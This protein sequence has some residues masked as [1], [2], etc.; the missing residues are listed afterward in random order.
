MSQEPLPHHHHHHH[1]HHSHHNKSTVQEFIHKAQSASGAAAYA[2]AVRRYNFETQ[3]FVGREGVVFRR[4]PKPKSPTTDP[5]T[6]T[7][8]GTGGDSEVP[9]ADIQNGM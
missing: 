3:N 5:G 4:K 2:R 9:A 1:H 8:T 7:T 6:G